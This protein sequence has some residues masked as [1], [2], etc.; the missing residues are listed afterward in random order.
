M[1]KSDAL[2]LAKLQ[3]RENEKTRLWGLVTEPRV[4]SVLSLVGGVYTIEHMRFAE[5]EGRNQRLKTAL[6][7][8]LI[9]QSLSMAG[10]KGWPAAVASLVGGVGLGSSGG[11]TPWSPLQAGE[12]TVIGAGLG[13]VVPGV[14]TLVGGGVGLGIDTIYQWVT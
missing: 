7:A 11:G 8:A 14:G 10:A 6:L 4:L 13:S 5:N 9:Y 1:P 12:A 3:A 2:K